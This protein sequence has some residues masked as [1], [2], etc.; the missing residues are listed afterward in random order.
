M[1]NDIISRYILKNDMTLL[2]FMLEKVPL[3][4]YSI[5]YLDIPLL[6]NI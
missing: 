1:D 5:F 6:L 3:C 4:L 2:I